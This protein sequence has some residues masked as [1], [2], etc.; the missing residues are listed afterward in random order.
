MKIKAINSLYPSEVITIPESTCQTYKQGD[1]QFIA[2]KNRVAKL[3]RHIR[4]EQ[5]QN[6]LERVKVKQS[7]LSL[8]RFD[9]TGKIFTSYPFSFFFFFFFFIVV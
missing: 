5:P 4:N 8:N 7:M 6:S 1:R 3:E 2:S 9:F